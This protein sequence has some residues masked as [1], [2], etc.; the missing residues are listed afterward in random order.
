[1]TPAID[2]TQ[3]IREGLAQDRRDYHGLPVPTRRHAPLEEVLAGLGAE[4]LPEGSTAQDDQD[5]VSSPSPRSNVVDPAVGEPPSAECFR[6]KGEQG[7]G[8]DSGT[9][10]D[11]DPDP[12]AKPPKKKK[13]AKKAEP[14]A[15]VEP[16]SKVLPADSPWAPYSAELVEAIRQ[17]PWKVVDVETTGLTP[18]SKPV[19]LTKKAQREGY[20]NTLR[21]RIVTVA[22]PEDG[23]VRLESFDLDA[24]PFDTA[25]R[26]DLAEACQGAVFVGHNAGFDIGWLQEHSPALPERVI[27]TLIHGRVL[28][29][30]VP[31]ESARQLAAEG[32]LD[33]LYSDKHTSGWALGDLSETLLD[34]EMDKGYQHPRHWTAPVPLSAEHYAYATGDVQQTL[35]V[36]CAMVGVEDPMGWLEAYEALARD[37]RLLRDYEQATQELV[38]V[39]RKGLPLDIERV[40][41]YVKMKRQLLADSAAELLEVA[42]ELKAHF[43]EL[44]NPDSGQSHDLRHALAK[45]FEDRGVEVAQ[46]EK[47]GLPMVGEKDLRRARA[48]D[49][50][51]AAPLYHA[52]VNLSKAKKTAK[53]A[54]ELKGFAERSA[55]GRVHSLLAP[56]PVTMR[57]SSSE[58]NIQQAPREA[59]FRALVHA[60]EGRKIYSCDYAALDMRSGESLAL[61]TQAEILAYAGRPLRELREAFVELTGGQDRKLARALAKAVYEGVNP[62]PTEAALAE[63]GKRLARTRKWFKNP[64]L[65]RELIRA[66]RDDGMDS[67]AAREKVYWD[68]RAEVQLEEDMHTLTYRL[69]EVRKHAA[70]SGEPVWGALREAFRLGADV[71]T[72]TALRMQG[73]DPVAL[74]GAL[75]PEARAVRQKELKHELGERRQHGKVANLGLLYAMGPRGFQ[76]YAAKG[77]GLHLEL[78]E[79]TQI[80]AQWLDAYPEVDLWR[81]WTTYTHRI[82]LGEVRSP[83]REGKVP[84]YMHRCET[85]DGRVLY[86][87][88]RNA[89][90][91]YP[92][93]GTGASV[94][95]RVL[96]E[97]Y[98][99]HRE[100]F[101]CVVNQIHDEL[102]LEFPEDK[103]EEYAATT[104]SVMET[105]GAEF[106]GPYGVELLAEGELGDVWLKG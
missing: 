87:T 29:P 52:L 30:E 27:D 57:L 44:A 88:T 40:D 81:L 98:L 83:W 15:P 61:R 35:E 79:A 49:I 12:P 53:M 93:Q 9:P 96:H 50:E 55:D 5:I 80:R 26:A 34:V 94:L 71:H 51:A 59:E 24:E 13:A 33:E 95:M 64:Q 66:Y 23:R 25:A 99:E 2:L 20:D 54:A 58:P 42:P 32:K 21:L 84:C 62:E 10:P 7:T 17:A 104:K 37:N 69:L 46:T 8:G 39:R 38:L 48:E 90:M 31:L 36:L 18:A 103:A 100:V 70:T 97:L 11:E 65:D 56:I 75:E 68:T 4:V 72:F 85:L 102:L 89:A 14:E 41:A 43:S 45:A 16:P 73:E 60:P 19:K 86:A 74:L 3:R 67:K 91:A 105:V 28:T 78:K 106:M 63:A 6:A 92:D 77:F 101:D 1:M 76:V 82:Y 47:S 22:W